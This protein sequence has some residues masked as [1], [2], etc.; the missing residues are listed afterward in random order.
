MNSSLFIPVLL[1]A[2]LT[3][4][5]APFTSSE[6]SQVVP[7]AWP[8]DQKGLDALGASLVDQWMSAVVAKDA[9]RLESMMLPCFQRISCAGSFDRASEI[10]AIKSLDAKS[11][12]VTDVK[13]TRVGDALVV[14]CQ[15]A[16][17]E[18]SAGAALPSEPSCRLGVWNQQD[19][20]WKLAAWAT[21][22]MPAARPAPSAPRFT[23][24]EGVGKEGAALV[25]RFL[26]AQRAKDLGPF[27]AMMAEGMQVINFRGQKTK[28]DLVKGASH[29]KADAAVLADVRATRCNELLVVTCNLAMGQK[30]GFTTLP[31]D[32]APFLAVFQGTGDAVKVI[33]MANTNK[34]K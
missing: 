22:H 24:D 13:V 23:S 25:T 12:K 20:T 4:G 14:T 21:L 34:P 26:E 19:R 2:T 17:E 33:A 27:D 30:M 11:P 29:V 32:P 1:A 6:P 15:V 7:A 9:A 10:E 5:S 8:S 3:L 28:E 31:A 16:V 18:R